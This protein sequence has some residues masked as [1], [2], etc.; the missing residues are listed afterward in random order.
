MCDG[1]Y[2]VK[3]TGFICLNFL[4][5]LFSN[6]SPNC[7]FQRRHLFDFLHCVFS[8]KPSKHL[9]RRMKNHTGRICL[10]LIQCV[11]LNVSSNG[12]PEGIHS[13]TGC[14][15]LIFLH[16]AFSNVSAKCLHQMMHTHTGC[17]LILDLSSLCIFK[18]FLISPACEDA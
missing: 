6:V 15:C 9:H 13:H 12:L 18:C 8:I 7:L 3:L 2:R 16:C 5:R 10:T 17:I 4:F 1:G 11:F 14:I